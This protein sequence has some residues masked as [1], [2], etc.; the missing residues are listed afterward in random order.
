MPLLSELLTD[1]P[2]I[3]LPTARSPEAHVWHLYVVLLEGIDRQKLMQQLSER[4]I[5]TAIHYPTPVPYQPAYVHLGY[6]RGDF[7][8]ASDVTS[9]CLSLPMFPSL[10]EEQ[11]LYMADAIKECLGCA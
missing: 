11:I 7:P 9:R 2:G 10:T 1:V 5:A 6:Q 8:V 3:T 4:G